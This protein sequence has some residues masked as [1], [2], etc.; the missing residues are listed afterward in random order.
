MQHIWQPVRLRDFYDV[1]EA[2]GSEGAGAAD[3]REEDAAQTASQQTSGTGMRA[4]SAV[5]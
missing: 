4:W 3:S 1:I 2:S 5:V